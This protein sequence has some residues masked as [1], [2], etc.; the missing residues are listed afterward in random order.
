M[1]PTSSPETRLDFFM[2]CAVVAPLWVGIAGGCEEGWDN[3]EGGELSTCDCGGNEG[4]VVGRM[5]VLAEVTIV[6]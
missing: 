1:S 5:V 4:L 2:V 6:E 3:E